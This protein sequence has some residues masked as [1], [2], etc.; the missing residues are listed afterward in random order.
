MAML[1][2]NG[3]DITQYSA[4]E[5]SPSYGWKL[6]PNKNKIAGWV[7]DIDSIKQA[8]YLML[9]TERGKYEIYP[10]WYGMELYDLYGKPQDL[11]TVRLPSLV[12]DC[13]LTDKRI[14]SV[15]NFDIHFEGSKCICKFTVQ[16][17]FGE[18]QSD[19]EY[20]M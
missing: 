3:L 4:P 16:S 10:E 2:N 15:D 13:L 1:P 19:V 7:D 14:T 5:L 6:D 17:V 20:E 8:I 9:R 18:F 12:K 11:V